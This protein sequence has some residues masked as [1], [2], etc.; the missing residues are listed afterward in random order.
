MK[1]YSLI[2]FATLAA[3]LLIF[4]ACAP[5]AEIALSSTPEL[6]PTSTAMP[7]ATPTPEPTP[8]PTLS[9][10]EEK[11]VLNQQFQDFF[12]KEG[13]FTEEK[14]GFHPIYPS[15]P[16]NRKPEDEVKLGLLRIIDG[17]YF[18]IYGYLFD[19]IITEENNIILILGFD[20]KDGN[21]FITPVEI[22]SSV[23]DH[24]LDIKEKDFAAFYISEEKG[25]TLD[26]D[27]EMILTYGSDE[28][29][30]YIKGF[31]G[32]RIILDIPNDKI[33][34][35]SLEDKWDI[36]YLN[37]LEDCN[38]SIPYVL[39]LVN[40]LETNGIDTSSVRK[41]SK[42]INLI[43]NSDDINSID[44]ERIIYVPTIRHNWNGLR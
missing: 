36:V 27:Y 41:S 25:S 26:A 4:T 8:K 5:R 30:N 21:R 14:L 20:G 29:A 28:T 17:D 13:D 40:K 22:T 37:Y 10:E 1:R 11:E 9:P 15:Q 38:S 3:V 33:D 19:S 16:N 31:E 12:N 6:T 32:D 7:T 43:S 35:K 24:F 39:S 2:I 42:E 34:V 23:E 18:N 44:F